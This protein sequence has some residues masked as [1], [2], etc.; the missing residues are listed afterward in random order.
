MVRVLHIARDEH[1]FPAG[2]LYQ[3]LSLLGIIVLIQ[4]G[5]EQVRAL[6]RIC[7]GDRA[8]DS[9]VRAGDDSLLASQATRAPVGLFAMIGHRLHCVSF[10]GHWLFL[11]GKG[12]LRRLVHSW[13]SSANLGSAGSPPARSTAKLDPSSSRFLCGG[14]SEARSL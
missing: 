8:A 1:S 6:A 10:T 7:N 5:N 11:L 3:F 9:A 14:A 12:G 2:V 4:I 13:P